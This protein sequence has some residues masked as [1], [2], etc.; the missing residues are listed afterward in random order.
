MSCELN[1]TSDQ[2]S[3]QTSV[4]LTT[5]VTSCESQTSPVVKQ[6]LSELQLRNQQ[7]LKLLSSDDLARVARAFKV[8]ED[9]EDQE[10]LT[11]V[12]VRCLSAS[13]ELYL[14]PTP[15]RGLSIKMR[16]LFVRDSVSGKDKFMTTLLSKFP[17]ETPTTSQQ[18]T[19]HLTQ[20][21][22]Q[23]EIVA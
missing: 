10:D 3:V 9:Q 18:W 7:L 19:Q 4:G 15:G 17:P 5:T 2:A 12:V 22:H 8:S 23:Q 1:L 6:Q 13:D 16:S 21:S 14:G 11:D 20:T